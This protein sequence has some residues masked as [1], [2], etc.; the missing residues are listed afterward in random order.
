MPFDMEEGNSNMKPD[1][2]TLII[3]FVRIFV[4]CFLAWG[5]VTVFKTV[6]G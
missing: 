1:F 2:K 4:L 5:I 6:L 3:R